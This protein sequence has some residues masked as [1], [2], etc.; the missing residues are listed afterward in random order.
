MYMK[1]GTVLT[2]SNY[3]VED[4][5][6]KYQCPTHWNLEQFSFHEQTLGYYD[7]DVVTRQ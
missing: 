7:L 4:A 5:H 3:N 1:L 6:P 2:G